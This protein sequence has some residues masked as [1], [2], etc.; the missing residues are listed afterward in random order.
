MGWDW[1]IVLYLKKGKSD[2]LSSTGFRHLYREATLRSPII[3]IQNP[4]ID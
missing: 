2:A 3:C 1:G 4:H